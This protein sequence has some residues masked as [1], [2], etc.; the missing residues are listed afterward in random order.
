MKKKTLSFLVLG[1]SLFS[2]SLVFADSQTQEEVAYVEGALE[3][4][5]AGGI[6]TNLDF[7]DHPLQ[8][9]A[10]E[11][12][13][14]TATGEQT[15]ST[16]TTGTVAVRDN[17]G[18]P[19]A[20]WTVKLSQTDQFKTA[21]DVELSG[22]QLNLSFGALTN[23]LGL[24]PTS[25]YENDE[26]AIQVFNQDATILDATAGQNSGDTAL[27]INQFSLSVPANTNK[28]AEQYTTIL[29]WTFSFSPTN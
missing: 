12:W 18:N 7:G 19:A 4:D 23:N 22:A 5:Y 2:S 14:A 24:A 1:I 15:G 16:P 9:A 27:A 20:T 21:D 8:T 28:V 25:A 11:N 29:N 10:A 26:L 3:F 6:P 13:I 17:R